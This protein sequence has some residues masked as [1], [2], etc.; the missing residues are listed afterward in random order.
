MCDCSQAGIWQMMGNQEASLEKKSWQYST[1]N[2]GR[3]KKDISAEN[4][5]WLGRHPFLLTRQFENPTSKICC[6]LIVSAKDQTQEDGPT[7][8]STPF[9]IART[10]LKNPIYRQWKKTSPRVIWTQNTLLLTSQITITWISAMNIKIQRSNNTPTENVFPRRTFSTLDWDC[11]KLS[12]N[13][14][15]LELHAIHVYLCGTEQTGWEGGISQGITSIAQAPTSAG[16]SLTDRSRSS[17]R[18]SSS[19]P[20]TF[21]EWTANVKARTRCDE[22]CGENGKQSTRGGFP[23]ADSASDE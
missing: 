11:A 8:T 16:S 2:T 15:P 6:W 22:A 23:N 18:S 21:C 10:T 12:S 3:D 4:N 7:C 13:H 5:V 17:K 19:T 20:R 9:S 14:D 1:G